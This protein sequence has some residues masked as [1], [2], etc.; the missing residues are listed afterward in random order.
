MDFDFGG[1]RQQ[2]ADNEARTVAERVHSEERVRRLVRQLNQ[3]AQLFGREN[4]VGESVTKP[5][6]KGNV[7]PQER[8]VIPI[9][10]DNRRKGRGRIAEATEADAQAARPY[11]RK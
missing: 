1:V 8:G 5:G 6:T 11:Q 7:L 3:A 4:H 2:R 10:S 9:P